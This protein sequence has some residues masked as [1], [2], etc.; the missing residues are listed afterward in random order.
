MHLCPIS[1][2]SGG[3]ID[4]I[5]TQRGCDRT[6]LYIT[7][8][9]FVQVSMQMLRNINTGTCWPTQQLGSNIH[10]A[11]GTRPPRISHQ[12]DTSLYVPR[13]LTE[14]RKMD[15]PTLDLELSESNFGYFRY[16]Q[17]KCTI[18]RKLA[19]D[20][21]SWD[22]LEQNTRPLSSLYCAGAA[23]L[24]IAFRSGVGLLA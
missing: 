10:R 20:E 3:S 18:V 21:V 12:T 23:F 19:T 7:Y 9:Q 22:Q 14:P 17:G 11:C 1:S 2:L 16:G 13:A 4:G 5:T 8:L 24:G 6:R 15:W